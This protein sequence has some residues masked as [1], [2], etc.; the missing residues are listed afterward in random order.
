MCLCINS[1]KE[2]NKKDLQEFI[3]DQEEVFVYKILKKWSH[4]DFYRSPYYEFSWDFK[5]QKDFE[6]ERPSKP[7]EEELELGSIDRG[8]H[9][10]TNLEAASRD[11]KKLHNYSLLSLIIIKFKVRV[12]DIVAI[13]NDLGKGNFQELVCRKLEFIEIIRD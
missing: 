11:K 13:E 4:E 10:Y 5:N 3:G 12:E 2:Q 1:N 6:I 9:A 8:F 7:T